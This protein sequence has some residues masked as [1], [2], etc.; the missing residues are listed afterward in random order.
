MASPNWPLLGFE[1]ARLAGVLFLLLLFLWLASV[2]LA[3]ARRD[4]FRFLSRSVV[5]EFTTP[6]GWLDLCFFGL[7]MV[8]IVVPPVNGWLLSVAGLVQA[9]SDHTLQN[10][11]LNSVLAF[12]LAIFS[13]LLVYLKTPKR[14]SIGRRSR[15]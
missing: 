12:L 6:L 5:A 11:Y 1:L 13:L 3:G 2:L 7:F 8:F 9:S 15:S 4:L 14:T 10:P